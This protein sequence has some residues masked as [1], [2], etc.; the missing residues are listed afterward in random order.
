M[1]SVGV[2]PRQILVTLRQDNKS[3][4]AI[5]KTIYNTKAQ[6][7]QKNLQSYLLMQVLLNE[8]NE[9]D[10]KFD[11]QYKKEGHITHLFFARLSVIK[12]SR[13][14]YS[15][16]L[17]DCTYKTNKFYMLLI[18]IIEMTSFNIIFTFCIVF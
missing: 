10:F 14:Y 16:L 17:I 15:V 5:S 7:Y 18:Y 1:I 4:A 12:L 6:I 13:I 8:L 2:L 11:F 9:K 3:C